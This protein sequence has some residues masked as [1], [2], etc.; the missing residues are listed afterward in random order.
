MAFPTYPWPVVRSAFKGD[1]F[2][3]Q[4][5]LTLESL[6]FPT[7][8]GYS[9]NNGECMVWFRN[10]QGHRFGP[11]SSRTEQWGFTEPG[12]PAKVA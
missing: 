12:Q 8:V 5:V 4:M 7:P 1:K 2:G 10:A 6:G 3:E 11:V 9:R